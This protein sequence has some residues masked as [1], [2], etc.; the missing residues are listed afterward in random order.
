MPYLDKRH[1]L[2]SIFYFSYLL[3]FLAEITG[4]HTIFIPIFQS[5]LRRG[6]TLSLRTPPRAVPSLG[7]ALPHHPALRKSWAEPCLIDHF[8]KCS[9]LSL[10]MADIS[11]S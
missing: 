1:S 11:H 6:G 8:R 10:A 5:F 3:F 4:N 7:E 9:R 2:H